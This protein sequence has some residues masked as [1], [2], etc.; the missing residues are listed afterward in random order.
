MNFTKGVYD[1][2]Q[3]WSVLDLSRQ[4][5]VSKQMIFNYLNEMKSKNVQ[6]YTLEGKQFLINQ[7]GYNYILERRSNIKEYT[8][9][10]DTI[11]G[12]TSQ[13]EIDVAVLKNEVEH[14]KSQLADKDNQIKRME[15]DIADYKNRIDNANADYKALT[16]KTIGLFLTDGSTPEQEPKKKFW[17]WNKKK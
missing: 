12:L 5:G 16:N 2:S 6:G 14:L 15:I 4:Y 13:L 7:D 10:S 17:W 3:N 11:P 9:K 8:K 1:M